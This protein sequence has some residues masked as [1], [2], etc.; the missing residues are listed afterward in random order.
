M[1]QAAKIVKGQKLWCIHR[2]LLKPMLGVV[3]CLT[4]EPGKQIG[5]QFEEQV[6]ARLAHLDLD[7][8]GKKGYCVWAH[9]SHVL[10]EQEY[11]D[12]LVSE[13]L[14]RKEAADIKEVDEIVLR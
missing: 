13:E 9:V 1:T 14:A 11:Q 10:T 12:K 7:G 6:P 3:I 5:L 2:Q 8:R 4:T